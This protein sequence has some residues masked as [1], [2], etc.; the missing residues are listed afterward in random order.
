MVLNDICPTKERRVKAF[1]MTVITKGVNDMLHPFIAIFSEAHKFFTEDS[2]NNL[3]C[4]FV[5]SENRR[6]I[7]A[8]L[9]WA[10]NIHNYKYFANLLN[11]FDEIWY[12]RPA[13]SAA[14]HLCVLWQSETVIPCFLHEYERNYIYKCTLQTCNILEVKNALAICD[15]PLLFFFYKIAFYVGWYPKRCLRLGLWNETKVVSKTNPGGKSNSRLYE[16][17]Q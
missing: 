16:A 13:H 6:G 1:W 8:Q 15:F 14:E 2:P 9:Y 12:K 3:L 17:A 11:D 10:V 7:K 5:F 4:N